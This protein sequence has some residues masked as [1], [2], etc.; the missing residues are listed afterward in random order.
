MNAIFVI[1]YDYEVL[2]QKLREYTDEGRNLFMIDK[3]RI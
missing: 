3:K 2:I 1:N